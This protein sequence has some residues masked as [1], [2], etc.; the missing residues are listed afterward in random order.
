MIRAFLLLIP[1]IILSCT[2]K[3]TTQTANTTSIAVETANVPVFN[4]DSAYK[5]VATQVEF[6]P[7]VPETKEHA[8]CASYLANSL[9]RFGA[10]V[11]IQEGEVTL[12]NKKKINCKNIIGQFNKKNPN[13]VVLF[14]HW[15][16]R[17]YA[18]QASGPIEQLQPIDGASDG[19]SGVGV[20]LEIA[21]QLGK[22]SSTVGVDIIFFDVEDYGQP[23]FAKQEYQEHSWCLGAQFWGNNLD[24]TNYSPRY[25]ILLDMVGAKD[26]LFYKEGYSMKYA[27]AVV[28]KVWNTASQ[29]GFGNFFIHEN[30]S[31]ITDDHLY[32]NSLTGIPTIDIIQF[33]PQSNTSFGEYWHTHNDNMSIIDRT[34][35]NAVGQT[36]LQVIYSEK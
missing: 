36:L 24:M 6:G 2:S 5:Y 19:A 14:A 1:T 13:R 35:L 27:P 8:K 10:D 26:A 25:G 20:L 17:P 7:R 3:G 12:Y 30:G 22:S 32:V 11:L 31:T 18:D 9:E 16:T 34:T 15:D 29:L 21:R 33:D 23:H 28:E 4:A